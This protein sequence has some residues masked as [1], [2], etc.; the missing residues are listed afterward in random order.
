MFIRLPRPLLSAIYLLIP[1][2]IM[3]QSALSGYEAST[4]SVP[5][6]LQRFAGK[7]VAPF[8]QLQRS[9]SIAAKPRTFTFPF[10]SVSP[11]SDEE[12]IANPI[13]FQQWIN[14]RL[15]T[16]DCVLETG[17]YWDAYYFE[18]LAGEQVDIHMYENFFDTVLFLGNESGSWVVSDDDTGGNNAARITATVPETGV[19]L[20]IATSYYPAQSS[21]Y[22]VVLRGGP[23]CTYDI[24]PSSVEVPPEGGTFSYAVKTLPR[25]YFQARAGDMYVDSNSLT[26]YGQGLGN[27][28]VTYTVAPNPRN[29]QRIGGISVAPYPIQANHNITQLPKI[30]TYTFDPAPPLMVGPFET[31]G[32]I[33]V[34]SQQGCQWSAS[35]GFEANGS[36]LNGNGSVSYKL[37]HNN[38]PA[39]SAS[40]RIDN[41]MYEVQQQGLNCTYSIAPKNERLVSGR[42]TEG[43]LNIVTQPNCTW[44]MSKNQNW[45]EMQPLLSQGQGSS[46]VPFKVLPVSENDDRSGSIRFGYSYGWNSGPST[47]V[48]IEQLPNLFTPTSDFDGDGISD[49]SV[50]DPATSTWRAQGSLRTVSDVALG[51]PGDKLVPADYD[52]DGKTDAAVFTPSTGIWRAVYSS[53]GQTIE[54]QLGTDGDIAV[55]EDYDGDGKADPAVYRPSDS[56]WLINKSLSGPGEVVFGS[57]NS[58][59]L[60]ADWNNDGKADP[61]VFNKT[62]SKWE[63]STSMTGPMTLSFG[64]PDD[65]I[66]AADYGG[67]NAQPSYYRP[68]TGEWSVR[69][70][71]YAGQFTAQMPFTAGS[72][73]AIG[74]FDG[75]GRTDPTIYDPATGNW[76]TQFVVTNSSKTIN[77]GGAGGIPVSGLVYAPYFPSHV[78]VSGRVVAPDGRGLRNVSVSLVSGNDVSTTVTSSLGYFAFENVAVGEYTLRAASK[79]YR[80]ESPTLSLTGNLADLMI[81]GIE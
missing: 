18:A 65:F 39:R 41:V 75:D 57:I 13:H 53:T 44:G 24:T 73:P 11:A 49:I 1:V 43:L 23:S 2:A 64:S 20:I 81:V 25:C 67:G 19:Y 80:F 38:G 52:G 46:S 9:L 71:P 17:Q 10:N 68:S 16:T 60:P 27:G 28:E 45:I 61:A 29:Q 78:Q 55:P 26:A 54:F 4:G 6:D 50:F 36:A 74:D 63:L 42:G 59:P 14:G 12:C 70:I 32:T 69:N 40:I 58:L 7:R 35:A 31:A 15:E 37:Y 22:N 56:R 79:R 51:I 76:H 66:F 30:C 5:G 72:V 34:T 48:F 21:N 8:P 77:F 33:S 62:T 3:P 47:I